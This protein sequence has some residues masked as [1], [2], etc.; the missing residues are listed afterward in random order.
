M[1]SLALLVGFSHAS[2]SLR[3]PDFDGDGFQDSATSGPNTTLWGDTEDGD[4][5]MMYGSLNGLRSG[6]GQTDRLDLSVSG[7][8]APDP[9]EARFGEQLAWG[10]FNGDCLD[11]LVVT[12]PSPGGQIA[13]A[14]VAVYPG[15]SL[16]PDPT[17]AVFVG[18]LPAVSGTTF[19]HLGT[20]VAA[21]D[22]DGDGRDDLAISG[23]GHDGRVQIHYGGT[24]ARPPMVFDDT[25][26]LIDDPNPDGDIG[27]VFNLG[28]TLATGDFNCDGYTDLAASHGT[29]IF[30]LHG[31]AAGL[32]G[33]SAWPMTSLNDDT[34]GWFGTDAPPRMTAM[35][36]GNFNGD[37]Q[38]EFACDDLAGVGTR[39]GDSYV[40]VL[41]GTSATG[42]QALAPEDDR[43][44]RDTLGLTNTA[45]F[46]PVIAAGRFDADTYEDL[47]LSSTTQGHALIV[48]GTSQGLTTSFYASW[49]RGD[50]LPGGGESLGHGLGSGNY[51]GDAHGQLDLVL[52]TPSSSLGERQRAGVVFVI[53]TAPT[54]LPGLDDLYA[55][56]ADDLGSV[57]EAW[58][59]F[60][61]RSLPARRKA[62]CT[63]TNSNPFGFGDALS[64]SQ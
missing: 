12:V 44:S 50:E 6:I 1:L 31:S 22:F 18:P 64:I 57:S 56:T 27:E 54:I 17:S 34:P 11:D 19:S 46:H 20:A 41:Y 52:G 60:G 37:S 47:A 8:G 36:S 38:G 33:S 63:E 4:V 29:G 48:R 16:G 45:Q 51:D 49:E 26:A 28:Q 24:N 3:G 10:D 25:H 15:S 14:V 61:T 21:G 13:S 35:T 7:V 53:D 59:E 40:T 55:F 43:F 32:D 9:S 2:P 39:G 58:A 30:V 42:L 62:V 23:M 5:L